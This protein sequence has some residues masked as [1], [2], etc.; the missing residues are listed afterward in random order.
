MDDPLYEEL[1]AKLYNVEK[2]YAI[3][4]RQNSLMKAARFSEAAAL[5]PEKS[6]L[7]ESVSRMDKSMKPFIIKNKKYS[8]EVQA[9]VQKINNLFNILIKIEKENADMASNRELLESGRHV[10]EY[11][12]NS[13]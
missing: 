1:T 5:E 2:I 13:K 7:M 6:G 12:R 9:T 3:A 11:K 4:E 10:A 8:S